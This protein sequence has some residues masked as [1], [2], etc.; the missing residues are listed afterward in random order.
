MHFSVVPTLILL[1][2][3]ATYRIVHDFYEKMFRLYD[4]YQLNAIGVF[5]C[6]HNFT[7]F[8]PINNNKGLAA[9]EQTT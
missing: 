5:I 8:V 3:H 6:I 1:H 4:V 7:F 9:K 2:M